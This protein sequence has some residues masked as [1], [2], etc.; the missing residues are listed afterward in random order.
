MLPT[1]GSVRLVRFV[2]L[3]GFSSEV[4]S[5]ASV[6][7]AKAAEKLQDKNE[8]TFLYP[9]HILVLNVLFWSLAFFL[10]FGNCRGRILNFLFLRGIWH[11]F[12]NWLLGYGSWFRFLHLSHTK[13]K[14]ADKFGNELA[15]IYNINIFQTEI[16]KCDHKR[17]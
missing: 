8:A 4:T 15:N 7:P 3:E 10:C 14:C 12:C 13:G 5:A 11:F 6:K 17:G 16:A 9:F 2:P 1:Q